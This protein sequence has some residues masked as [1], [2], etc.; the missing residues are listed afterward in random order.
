MEYRFTK[1]LAGMRAIPRFVQANNEVLSAVVSGGGMVDFERVLARLS[2]LEAKQ[3]VHRMAAIGERELELRLAKN[4]RWTHLWPLVKIVRAKVPAL[5]KLSNMGLPPGNASI[6]VLAGRADSIAKLVE[7]YAAVLHTLGL[8]A[9]FLDQLRAATA[10]LRAAGADKIDHRAA[11]VGATSNIADDIREAKLEL[12]AVDWLVRRKLGTKHVLLAEWVDITRRIRRALR[13]AA[14][15]VDPVQDPE[16]AP[17]TPPVHPV[18]P[19]ALVVSAGAEV[20]KA[21]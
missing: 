17:S 16:V 9:D 19:L 4:L 2:A 12:N 13:S 20:R 18:S 7:P 11:R 8:E 6:E 14:K 21:A 10:E 15:S 5:A 1:A 3:D